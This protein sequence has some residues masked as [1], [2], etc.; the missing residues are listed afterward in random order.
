[1]RNK[2]T[3]LSIAKNE[4]EDTVTWKFDLCNRILHALTVRLAVPAWVLLPVRFRTELA[5]DTHVTV[6]DVRGGV[7]K[8]NNAKVQDDLTDTRA[9]VSKIRRDMLRTQR[10]QKGTDD[11][12]VDR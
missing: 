1:M 6:S 12:N 4:I 8:A 9:M 7:T 5:T 3:M 10:S 2:F 11:Q